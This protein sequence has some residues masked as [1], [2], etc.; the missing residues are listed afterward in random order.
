M[1]ALEPRDADVA[2]TPEQTRTP[3]TADHA[4]PPFDGVRDPGSGTETEEPPGGTGEQG[5]RAAEKG[6]G[7]EALGNSR[8]AVAPRPADPRLGAPQP[9]DPRAGVL[10]RAYRALSIGIVSVVLLIAFEA[11]AVGTAMPVAARELDGVSLYAFAFSGYFTTSLLGMV[12]S[13]QWADR[14]GPLGPLAAGIS[15]FGA[16]LLLS[17]TAGSMW[18]F[19][20]GRAVQGLGGGLV[21]VALY[22]LVGRAYP[23]RLR[24]SIMAAFAASWVV[25]SVVG[26]LAAGTVTERLGWRWVFL[27]IPVLVLLPM[28][29][30]L[31]QIR[32]R[33]SGPPE[34]HGEGEP[35]EPGRA[36]RRLR[37]AFGISLGAGLVQYAAQDLSWW[38]VLPGAAGAVLLVPAVRGLLPRGTYRAAR[39]LPSV[40]LLRGVAAG[41]FIAAES[42]I[43]LMLVTQR[44]LSPTMAG[45][46]LALGGGT[47]ALGSFVQSRPR[48]EP[49]RER[50]IAFGMLLVA[51]A[52]ATAPTVLLDAVPV[53]IIAVAWGFG[54]FGMGLVISSTSVLLL[55]LSTPREAGS[56]SAALQ[57][58]D[59]LSNVVL[60]AA[61]G[62]AFAALGGGAVGGTHEVTSAA[63]ASHPGAFLVVFVPMAVV[64][65]AGAWIA[66]RLRVAESASGPGTGT[67]TGRAAAG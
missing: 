35:A 44:G 31:P 50:L 59:G 49:Y 14:Q 5:S 13:G 63:S 27:G 54:C 57:I 46:S 58:S 6:S 30:A 2:P 61:G 19:I 34:H 32:R 7:P 15:A 51:A 21:I 11:T 29:L 62:A 60:L 1:A 36:A 16:G 24:P 28:A 52:I 48:V 26:P 23:E 4:A 47:W 43:P 38:S 3:R 42:F 39:G 65:L 18:V 56:N 45:V 67:G 41:S 55:K 17:G 37:L 22:V 53:W 40:V 66:G 12:L 33:A 64:A 20:A 25:P 9:A 8:K 10:S